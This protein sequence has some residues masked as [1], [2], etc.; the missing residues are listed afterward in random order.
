ME[1]AVVPLL[2]FQQLLAADCTKASK[3]QRGQ[4]MPAGQLQHEL[5]G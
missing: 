4:V 3:E 1:I 2:P 5:I